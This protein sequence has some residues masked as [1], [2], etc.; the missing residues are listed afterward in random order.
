MNN[1]ENDPNV[2][3]APEP[4]SIPE[5]LKIDNYRWLWFGQAVSVAGDSMAHIALILLI[6]NLTGGS[7]QAIA[8]L[9][10][11]LGLPM[12]TIGLVAGVFVDR[13]P[14]RKIMIWSD[15]VRGLLV[16]AFVAFVLFGWTNIW[17]LYTF[18]FA[19][20]VVNSFFSPA[21]QAITPTIIPTEGLMAA[22]SLGQITMVLFAVIG[23]A[24][25]GFIVGV[26]ENYWVV[27]AIDA[28]TFFLSALFISLSLI[29][30]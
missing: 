15:I 1:E 23:T 19:H 13:F 29:H 11:A 8:N 2:G 14:R 7:T 26:F 3:D 18:A 10:I 27:F 30:I 21:R 16:L 12:A 6:N 4:L 25:G 5:V 28:V 22:N 17:Y 24:I 9:L 20:A